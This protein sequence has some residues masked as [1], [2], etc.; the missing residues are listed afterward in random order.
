MKF[1]ESTV[2]VL[3]AGSS[4]DLSL[5]ELRLLASKTPSKD[6]IVQGQQ[7]TSETCG[8]QEGSQCGRRAKQSHYRN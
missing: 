3:E 6:R 4:S 1:K 2:L 8:Y 7:S 5:F